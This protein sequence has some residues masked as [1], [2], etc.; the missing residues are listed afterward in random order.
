MKICV[1]AISLNERNNVDTF[2]ESC[3]GADLVLVC[4]TG[5]TDG[6]P[7]RLRDLGAVVYTIT[8]T[9]WRFD[10]ARNTA[11][12]LIPADIDV[13]I[14]LDLDEHLID[15]WRQELE[16]TW[17]S[18]TT[19]LGYD[20]IWDWT[21]DGKPNTSFFADKIH[22]RH[23]YIWK[24]P[25]HEAL[26]YVGPEQEQKEIAANLTVAHYPDPNKSRQQY[27]SLLKLAVDEDPTND[28]MRYYYARELMFYER[29][30]EAVEQFKLHLSLPKAIWKE[31]RSA[32]YRN[33][34]HCYIKLNKTEEGKAAAIHATI[35]CPNTRESWLTLTRLSFITHDWSTCYLAATRCLS[36]DTPSQSYLN[37]SS[38]WGWEPYDYAALSAYQLAYYEKALE[39]GLKTLELN[40]NDQRLQANVEAYKRLGKG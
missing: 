27:I 21:E 6:T 39:Y 14:S 34:A 5:S 8:Q 23:N 22:A 32:S 30:E 24:H 37:E 4:D 40:P 2:M 12:N 38:C 17:T 11:L 3:K 9:P 31:E 19:R 10:I 33:M 28:R 13:C 25:C 29:Y 7:E 20:Y 15:G 36:I 35:E 1:Y 16:N 18:T 26:Y